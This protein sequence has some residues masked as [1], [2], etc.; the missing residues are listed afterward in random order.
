ME[1]NIVLNWPAI[2]VAAFWGFALGGFWY[3]PKAF[4][5]RWAAHVGL[6]G[7]EPEPA[8]LRRAMIMFVIAMFLMA[9]VLAHNIAAWTPATWVAGEEQSNWQY[10]LMAGFWT[11]LGFVLPIQLGVTGFE[12]KKWGYLGINTSYYLLNL[13]GMGVIIASWH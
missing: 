9:V 6:Q 10:G 13:L 7:K 4:G 1:P 2:C 3:S 8:A 11:W 5:D 12:L